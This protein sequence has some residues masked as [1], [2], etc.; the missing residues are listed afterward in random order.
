MKSK[1]SLR[2]KVG[3]EIIYTVLLVCYYW[4]WARR[5]WRDYYE[6]IQSM[7][8]V[9]TIVFFIIQSGRI[10]KYSEEEK[11]ELAIQNLRRADAVGLKVMT[12]A[13]AVIAF[14][15]GVSLIDGRTAGYALVG[16]IFALAVLRFIIFCVMDSKGV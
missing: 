10:R 13:A 8:I 16:T 2:E 11:D 3:T 1:V 9:F 4:M 15:G 14:A 12:A 7:V 6:V 5:D